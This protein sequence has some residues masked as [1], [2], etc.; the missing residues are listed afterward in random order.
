V[1]KQIRKEDKIQF[2]KS[3]AKTLEIEGGRAETIVI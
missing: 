2:D 1:E 3:L